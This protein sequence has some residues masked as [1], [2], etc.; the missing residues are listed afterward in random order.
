LKASRGRRGTVIASFRAAIRGGATCDLLW[1]DHRNQE[2]NRALL[3]Y[4]VLFGQLWKFFSAP[5]KSVKTKY[6]TFFVTL[7]F[8]CLGGTRVGR[9]GVTNY[10]AAPS[11]AAS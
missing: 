6:E 9:R 4:A 2:P 8:H 7:F 1:V 10:D 5:T 11:L 3:Y